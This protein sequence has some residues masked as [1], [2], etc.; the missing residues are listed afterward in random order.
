MRKEL[1]MTFEERLHPEFIPYL[2]SLPA[3]EFVP[4]IIPDLQ[5][6]T[7]E[8]FLEIGTPQDD[9]LSV[10]NRNI[11]GRDGA[12][13]VRVRVYEP[14]EKTGLIPAVEWIHGGAFVIGLPEMNDDL[15]V[16][17]AKENNCLV[18]SPDY[19]L[20]PQNPYPSALDDCYTTLLWLAKNAEELKVDVSRIAVAGVSA[21]G[22]LAVAVCLLARDKKGPKIKFQMPLYPMIDDRSNT[23]SSI[24]IQDGRVWNSANNVS[25][26]NMYLG[27]KKDEV[28]QY[29]APARATDLSG[30]PPAYICIGDLEP[31]RD[32]TIEYVSKLTK[33][34]VPVEF[35]LNP[36]CFH[37]CELIITDAEISKRIVTEYVQALKRG[38]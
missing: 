9:K 11:P 7:R 38:L 23:Q 15:C 16:R 22:G 6:L 8:H 13:D 32:E 14:K 33:A 37:G 27:G 29:A 34:G 28:S 31:F 25:C 30:L 24:E 3:L 2:S 12:P 19:R 35:H 10:Y 18:F 21:G 20:A 26:W 36:G 1:G 4:E 5:Q 17:I